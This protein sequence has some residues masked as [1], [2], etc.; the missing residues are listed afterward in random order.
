MGS[1]N[2]QGGHITSSCSNIDNN[3]RWSVFPSRYIQAIRNVWS[4]RVSSIVIFITSIINNTFVQMQWIF[5]YPYLQLLSPRIR[6]VHLHTPS[7]SDSLPRRVR[8]AR[9]CRSITLS[10]NRL[11]R[12]Q[13]HNVCGGIRAWSGNRHV[14]TTVAWISLITVPRWWCVD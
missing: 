10:P 9:W 3:S 14:D 13:Y 11:L 4:W 6:D 5:T 12:T 2:T 7:H 8:R 1:S